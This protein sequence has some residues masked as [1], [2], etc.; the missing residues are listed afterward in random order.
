MKIANISD[1]H[2]FRVHV[3]YPPRPRDHLWRI[4]PGVK[5]RY[6]HCSPVVKYHARV[7]KQEIVSH[8]NCKFSHFAVGTS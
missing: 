4:Y 2:I 1:S 3:G 7:L 5:L 8:V 6:K